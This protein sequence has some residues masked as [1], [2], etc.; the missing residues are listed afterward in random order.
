[1]K[2]LFSSKNELISRKEKEN[3]LSQKGT[4]FW[5]TGLSGSGKT[6]I[7]KLTAEKLHS[8]GI[9]TQVLDG[10]NIRLGVNNNLTFSEEDRTENIRRIAEITKLFIENGVVTICCFISP[11]KKMR[12]LAKKI[13]GSKDFNEIFVNTSLED[14]TKRDTKGLYKKAALGEIKNFTGVSAPFEEPISAELIIPTQ[15]LSAEDSSRILYNFALQLI[16]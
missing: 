1:M 7:A 5:L 15:N 10:D 8:D 14:C 16:K 6:T 3:L 13:I 11:T 9:L 12:S 2:N 4:C